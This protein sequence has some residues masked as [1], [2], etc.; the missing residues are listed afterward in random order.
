M[1]APSENGVKVGQSYNVEYGERG[2]YHDEPPIPFVRTILKTLKGRPQRDGYGLYVGCGNGRNYIPLFDAGLRL[3][4][5]DISDEAI[6]QV[7]ERRPE[8]AN[9]T[10]I[11]DFGAYNGAR[12]F[13]YLIAIQVFQHG[14]RA[15]V[16]NYLDRSRQVLK[17]GGLLFLRVNST[18]TQMVY[19]HTVTEDDRRRGQTIFYE[20]GPKA[21]QEVHFFDLQELSYLRN[22]HGF[23]LIKRA[24]LVIEQRGAP[25]EG[26][27][28]SQ[29]ETIWQKP[30]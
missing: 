23:E 19:Q 27:T 6:R 3:H 30:E 28:W 12:I 15:A 29:W 11:G 4:G 25:F 20:E 14:N 18:S 7:R 9:T 8:L 10:F 17:P 26:T 21:G 24:G 16:D 2:R 13:D 5:M 22:K 1:N